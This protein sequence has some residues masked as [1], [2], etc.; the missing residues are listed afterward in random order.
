VTDL[1]EVFEDVK[2]GRYQKNLV[3][4][5]STESNEKMLQGRG[6]VV[7][8]ENIEFID[9]P[10]V[11]PNGDVLVPKLNFHVKPGVSI[12][13]YVYHCLSKYI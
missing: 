6:E 11:S 8:S 5:S 10:I 1:L 4:S 13:K 12:F 3:S 7:K 2:A 9:V